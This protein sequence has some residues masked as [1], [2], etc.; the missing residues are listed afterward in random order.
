LDGYDDYNESC[1]DSDRCC[2]DL[3]ACRS[4]KG[5]GWVGMGDWILGGAVIVRR[6]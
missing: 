6:E 2:D 5:C 4:W 3:Q 1:T